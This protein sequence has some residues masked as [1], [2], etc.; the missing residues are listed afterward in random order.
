MSWTVGQSVV[1]PIVVGRAP[2]LA[3]LD[4]LLGQAIGGAGRIGVLAGEA[5]VGK[6]RL[7]DEVKRRAQVRGVAL[8][9]GHC[10]EPDRTLPYG[11]LLDLLRAHLRGRAGDEVAGALGLGAPHLAQLLPELANLVPRPTSTPALDPELEK[12]RVFEALCGFVIDLAATRPLLVVVEDLHWSDATSL[13]FL[14]HLARRVDGVPVLLLLTYRDDEVDANLARF[15]ASLDRQRLATELPVTHLSASDVEAM[16]RA[17]FALPRPAPADLLHVLFALTEGNPL[18]VEEL[19]K[20]LLLSGDISYANGAWHRRPVREWRIPRT[21]RDAV[22]RR[23]AALPL[24][25]QRILTLAAVAGLRFDF[26]LL[27]DLTALAEDELLAQITVLVQAQ[28]LVEE[29][30]DRFAFRHAL[31]REA[32]YAQ[33][34]GRERRALHRAVAAALAR[35]DA[36]D[37]DGRVAA[38]AYHAYEAED[39]AE[40]LRYAQRAGE[41]ALAL[42]APHAAVE[43]F[44]R[45]V[46][47]AGHLGQ[48]PSAHLLRSR[49]LAYQTLGEFEWA[50]ADHE[51]AR[52]GAQAAAD[53]PGEWQS[54]LDLGALWTERDYGLSGEYFRQ[55]L[56]LAAE[57]GD[58]LALPRSLN[59]LAN[60]HLNLDQP[61]DARRYHDQALRRFEALDQREGIAETLGFLG[62]ANAIG[63]DLRL[64]A[65]CYERAVALFRD[66]GD[67]QA[68]AYSLAALILGS[69]TDATDTL[70]PVLGLAEAARR[71]EE[72]LR[73]AREIGWRAG[74]AFAL[75]NLSFGYTAQGEYGRALAS[76]RESLAVAEGIEHRQ[77]S[78]GARWAL[79]MLHL[80]LLDTLAAREHLEQALALARAIGSTHWVHFSSGSLALAHLAAGDPA[81]ADAILGA[82]L[83]PHEA[84]NSVG[85]RLAW[86]ARAEHALAR[87]D[88]GRALE[89]VDQVRAATANLGHGPVPLR[90]LRLRGAALA[91]AGAP[92]AL[93]ALQETRQVAQAHGAQP[94][95]WRA[96]LAL[97]LH[98]RGRRRREEA[99]REFA[100]ARAIVQ[101][102][103]RGIP[104]EPL[105]GSFER[106]AGK[107]IPPPPRR[108][109]RRA[110]KE[111]FGGLTAR[112][113]EV[114]VLIGH[115]HTNRAIAA[116][117][118]LS[119]E[120]VV[121]H[122]K[123]IF[124]KLGFESRARVAAW[125][126]EKGLISPG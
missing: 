38:L 36:P 118:F 33:L 65:A 96:H 14:P 55:A 105:R 11:P 69:P 59:R 74:E 8:L 21:I 1:S 110:A 30:A 10:F 52:R 119:D 45:A 9:E 67:R 53:R 123:H 115:G 85:R 106:A 124:S 80:D 100:A 46:E 93:A 39:W 32:V 3:A 109:G 28:L 95:L 68:L 12:R 125:A 34:L 61:N 19:L 117:L 29:S 40:A 23:S 83:E 73:I 41:L 104:D 16:V 18:F 37:P 64:S 87:G 121:T 111:T 116:T 112:E 90:L 7:V 76:A 86:C 51:A 122:I 108:T 56:D 98:H 81:Q 94:Q 4:E 17:I 70:V 50:R 60:W 77:W 63:G 120:T 5:G 31:S 113:R 101:E 25:A 79:G 107:V 43:Q 49:G 84:A 35:L 88:P 91:M 44:T 102:L 66:L 22:Q 15:L 97:G 47:A 27:Q 24:P 78:V 13:E 75:F 48:S 6:S 71:G 92:E 20:S 126:A 89:V 26:A 62:M 103:A 42:D 99:E 58:P 54:L 2:L 72:G 82:A 114:A 57:L